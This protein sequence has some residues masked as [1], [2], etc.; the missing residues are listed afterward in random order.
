MNGQAGCLRTAR[1]DA[2]APSAGAPHAGAL[3]ILG[4]RIG[5]ATSAVNMQRAL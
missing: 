1:K 3:H 2:G 5:N 4:N